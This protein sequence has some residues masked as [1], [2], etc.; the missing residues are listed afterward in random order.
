MVYWVIYD[1]SKNNIRSKVSNLCKD[2]GLK[3]IQKSA[4]SGNLTRNKAEMLSLEI[5]KIM[6]SKNDKVL[7]FPSSEE[8]F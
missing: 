1:I 7:I 2:Y 6:K 5:K 4:F 3:R 8:E